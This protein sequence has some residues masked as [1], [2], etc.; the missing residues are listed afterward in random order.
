VIASARWCPPVP[1][2]NLH[3]KEGSRAHVRPLGQG[4]YAVTVLHQKGAGLVDL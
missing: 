4:G 2:G 3:G 1:P